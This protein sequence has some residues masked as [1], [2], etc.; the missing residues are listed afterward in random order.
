MPDRRLVVIGDGP[1]LKDLTKI[2]T[3]N[4]SLL[5]AQPH[6][7]LLE[8]LQ[9]AKAFLFAAEEDF[10]IAPIEAQACGTPVLAFGKGGAIET[11]LDGVTGY[12]FE[13]QT[14]KSIRD[15]VQRFEAGPS[16]NPADVRK[17]AHKF[18]EARFISQFSGFVSRAYDEH[19]ATLQAGLEKSREFSR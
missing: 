5:G 2:A 3:P 4:I 12:F 18:S 15:V 8:H 7:V 14:A 19:R 1:Q 9:C 10:G 11:V 13:E 6:N 17:N 16:F